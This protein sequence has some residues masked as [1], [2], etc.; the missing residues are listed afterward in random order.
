MIKKIGLGIFILSFAL[1]ISAITFGK[2]QLTKESVEQSIPK[3][4]YLIL[5]TNTFK[6]IEGT[7]YGNQFSFVSQ[8]K[9]MAAEANE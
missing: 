9:P 2:F 7:I 4:A 1:F 3:R 6:Q 5:Q 8:I